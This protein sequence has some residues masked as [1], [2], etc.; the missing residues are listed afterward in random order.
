MGLQTED[1]QRCFLKQDLF[2]FDFLRPCSTNTSPLPAFPQLFP[3]LIKQHVRHQQLDPALIRFLAPNCS[4]QLWESGS[5]TPCLLSCCEFFPLDQGCMQAGFSAPSSSEV[6]SLAAVSQGRK[7]PSANKVPV[8]TA[9]VFRFFWKQFR[10][11]LL[12]WP[13]PS[14]EFIHCIGSTF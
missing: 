1:K 11:V 10:P 4:D 9:L 3:F 7:L 2:L 14:Q 5:V 6:C 12:S 8:L 13:L